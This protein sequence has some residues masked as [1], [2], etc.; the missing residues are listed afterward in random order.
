MLKRR[1]DFRFTLESCKSIRI[2]R[3]WFLLRGV[4]NRTP[5]QSRRTSRSSRRACPTSPP[6]H[7]KAFS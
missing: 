5:R 7:G 2:W 3:E 6:V 4:S 1:E